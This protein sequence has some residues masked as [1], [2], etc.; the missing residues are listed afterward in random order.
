[1]SRVGKQPI[2]IPSDVTVTLDR[3][4][5][6]VKG[7]KGTLQRVFHPEM[8][9]RLEDSRILVTRPSDSRQHRALHGLTRALI[10]NMVI[11][12]SQGFRK[13]LEIIGVG[14][15][16]ELRGDA[17]LFTVGYSHPILLKAP[18]G[19]AF[20]V[21]KPTL[22]HVSGPDCELVGQ[23]AATARSFRPPD[24]YKGK[25]IKYLDEHVRRKAGKTS[26]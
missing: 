20:E 9:V 21:E 7:P 6:T 17:L 14:Y 11:G 19:I 24:P 13:S 18:P 22:F 2:P 3:N 23:V 5:I 15:R 8:E 4:K 1:M 12:V 16:V 26:K 10:A 25:G